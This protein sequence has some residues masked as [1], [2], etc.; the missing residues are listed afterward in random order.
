MDSCHSRG[1]AGL[2]GDVNMGMSPRLL[3]PRAGGPTHPEAKDWVSR[4]LA[5]GGSVSSS[6]ALAV[7]QFCRSIDAASGLRAALLR[8]NLLAGNNINACMV[9][10]YRAA[11][12]A[13]PVIGNST[14]TNNGPFVSGDFQER[15]NGGGLKGDGTSKYL[16]TGFQAASLSSRTDIHL[17]FSGTSL[18]TSGDKF[19]IGCFNGGSVPGSDIYA[20]DI[21][22]GYVSGRAARLSNYQ[23]GQFPVI[24]TPGTSE[25]H[26]IGT[27]TASN[28][29]TIYRGGSSAATNST[30]VTPSSHARTFFVF[31]NNSSGTAGAFTSARL[32]MYSIGNGLTA[33]QALTFSSAVIAFNTSLGRA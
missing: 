13:G 12:L 2:S 32:R 5:N 14:D 20:I 1:D 25:S 15:G 31:A 3:R 23:A 19:A 24:A 16:D 29:A 10:L 21:Y 27:R 22:A 11:S 33:A 28:L 7:D 4:V 6:T 30:T 9:P 8:V 18:E 17:S 26:F